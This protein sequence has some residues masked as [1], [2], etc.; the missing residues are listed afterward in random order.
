MVLYSEQELKNELKGVLD[1]FLVKLSQL[2][3][4]RARPD[5]FESIIVSAYETEQELKNLANVI[6]E[7][8]TSVSIIPWDKSIIADII[9]AIEDSKLGYS[10]VDSGDKIRINIPT[11]TEETRKQTVKELKGL[12]EDA[13]VRIRHVRHKFN[14]AVDKD[15]NTTEDDQ[16]VSRSAIQKQIDESNK[17][18]DK[19]ASLKEEELMT[20]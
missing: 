13:R 7:N 18:I 8:A 14:E 12:Q 20:L 4:G 1:D 6:V 2:R 15:D 16:K 10:P 5:M 17:E 11:L 9:K 19:I 3:A